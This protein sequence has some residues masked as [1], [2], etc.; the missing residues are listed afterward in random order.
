MVPREYD[1]H[2]LEILFENDSRPTRPKVPAHNKRCLFKFNSQMRA[3]CYWLSRSK[4]KA[5]RISFTDLMC[6]NSGSN[7][8]FALLSVCGQ[9]NSRA[10]IGHAVMCFKVHRNQANKQHRIHHLHFCSGRGRHESF[11]RAHSFAQRIEACDTLGSC[12][13]SGNKFY[14]SNKKNLIQS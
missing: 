11:V 9:L 10:L 7:D 13:H 5:V 12:Q 3:S 14:R 6:A 2:V 8:S 4:Q 1:R